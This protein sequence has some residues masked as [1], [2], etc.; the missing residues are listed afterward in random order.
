[1][2]RLLI[3]IFLAAVGY[4]GYTKYFRTPPAAIASNY[5]L[6]AVEQ[7]PIPKREFYS[8]WTDVAMDK[9]SDAKKAHN[10]TPEECREKVRQRSSS[11]TAAVIGSTPDTVDSV[12]LARELGRQHLECVTPHYFCK[13]VEVKTEEQARQHCQ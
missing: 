9:C 1:M 10:L 11:C 3:F 8:L 4:L 13:G 2:N 5:S 7:Q 6:S 12:A